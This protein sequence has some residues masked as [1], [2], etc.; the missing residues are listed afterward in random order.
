[1][2]SS[3]ASAM[4]SILV[5][6][7]A[8]ASEF[9]DTLNAASTEAKAFAAVGASMAAVGGVIVSSMLVM[10]EQASKFGR[11]IELMNE[12]TGMSTEMLSGLKYGMNQLNVPYDMLLMATRKLSTET[13][14][15]VNGNLA[16]MNAFRNI[17]VSA[18][19]AG[20]HIKPLQQLFIEI[21]D[22]LHNVTNSTQL[23]ADATLFFGRG[24]ERLLP[25]LKSGSVGFQ[26]WSDMAA[27]L[28]VSVT[29][30]QADMDRA[31][32]N[33]Q[34][35]V[36]A[37][38][39]GISMAI[40]NALMPVLIGLAGEITGMLT[41]VRQWVNAHQDVTVA[42]AATG[43]ALVGAGGLL[44]GVG[45]IL[46]ILPLTVT[47]FALVSNAMTSTAV[48]AT[49]MSAAATATTAGLITTTAEL[50]AIVAAGASAEAGLLAMAVAEKAVVAAANEMAA[51]EVFLAEAE[52]GVTDARIMAN[53]ALDVM[54]ATEANAAAA[55]GT[56]AAATAG[57]DAALA[58]MVGAEA[59]V[60][61]ATTGADAA[62]LLMTE[63]EL[64]VATAAADAS[65]ALLLTIEAGAG[66][67]AAFGLLAETEA[68]VAAAAAGADAALMLM[69]DAE[70]AVAVAASNAAI[71][72]T[73]LADAEAEV[74][75][76]SIP[77]EAAARR[78]AAA[79]Y[80]LTQAEVGVAAAAA[81]ADAAL[82]LMAEAEAAVVAAAA[83]AS[84]AMSVAGVEIAATTAVATGGAAEFS[85]MAYGAEALSAAALL[86]APALTAVGIAAGVVAAAWVAWGIERDVIRI[87]DLGGAL[88]D[89]LKPAG[90]LFSQLVDL[91]THAWNIVV[92]MSVSGTSVKTLVST[93]E[94]FIALK[95]R[96]KIDET[97]GALT[98]LAHAAQIVNNSLGS[99]NQQLDTFIGSQARGLDD[100]IL[101]EH[102]LEANAHAFDDY[103]KSVRL[104][105]VQQRDHVDVSNKLQD[106]IENGVKAFEGQRIA[107]QAMGPIAQAL[108]DKYGLEAVALSDLAP[109]IHDYIG[110]LED[111][112]SAIPPALK[113]VDDI[114][115]KLSAQ[116][117]LFAQS[118]EV[119]AKMQNQVI[120]TLAGERDGMLEL[121]E[122]M[123]GTTLK[124]WN[125]INALRNLSPLHTVFDDGMKVLSA[126]EETQIV[127]LG[128]MVN[129]T[130]MLLGEVLN[131][132]PATIGLTDAQRQATATVMAM[133]I[134]TRNAA[135]LH[136]ALT[137]AARENA[138][139]ATVFSQAW[140]HGLERLDNDMARTLA[141][142]LIGGKDFG[143]SMTELA[144]KT[145]GDMLTAFIGGF[146]TPFTNEL[147]SVGRDL[148]K[149]LFGSG[150]GSGIFSGIVPG[151]MGGSG[152]SSGSVGGTSIADFVGPQMTGQMGG[153]GGMLGSALGAGLIGAAIPI[154]VE[155]IGA[156]I[157]WIRGAAAPSE[158]DKYLVSAA[159]QNLQTGSNSSYLSSMKGYAGGTPYVP[160]TGP[161]LLHQGERVM[162]PMDNATFSAAAGGNTARLESLVQELIDA[163]KSGGEA[164]VYMDG[165]K[166]GKITARSSALELY[167]L[168]KT[169]NMQIVGAL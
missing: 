12:R 81:D 49:T 26:E 43:V 167:R 161:Y 140:E 129:G 67:D 106:A 141:N 23:A 38:I 96:E 9:I 61:A 145:A 113:A 102:Q 40:G 22:G 158:Q 155:G 58:L 149:S 156:L 168:T 25:M 94:T 75:A 92:N 154:A 15:A 137:K 148:S 10:T 41:R 133:N 109:K 63:A 128:D 120:D 52:L 44:V 139:A 111:I 169:Q 87:G 64:A 51:A 121:G 136:A 30:S 34:L 27:V 73:M 79:E 90:D 16:A 13:E 11:E 152:N 37:S 31:F 144:T 29:K 60:A 99:A 134:S 24:G 71:A 153:A 107:Q 48:A 116:H 72:Q 47:G 62:L 86:V 85:I 59:E 124:V 135:D 4:S 3:N 80:F 101:W 126:D 56:M 89:L 114:N 159:Y 76:A 130:N 66:A 138:N 77:A 147:R 17:G 28:G 166:V 35:N 20:G 69:V 105:I 36:E 115:T 157:K 21:S 100:E 164:A 8:D 53:A 70:A 2:P 163:V 122:A 93:F 143:K 54:V 57:A 84:T 88:K 50:D 19:D 104:L 74:I 5:K 119:I 110:K 123:S 160:E 162:S 118:M 142:V 18:T 151:I 32:M 45:A 132:N 131:L 150:Q 127:H 108:I 103:G 65:A 117:L 68:A 82:L 91:T 33:A 39:K 146:I 42:V 14:N 1:M 98:G 112:G 6:I 165:Q 95:I 97:N 46:A 55:L 7:T 78:L 125:Y 83:Q